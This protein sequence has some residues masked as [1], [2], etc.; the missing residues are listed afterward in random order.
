MKMIIIIQATN[1]KK[2]NNKTCSTT[3]TDLTKPSERGKIKRNS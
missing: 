1:R 3:S 2:M